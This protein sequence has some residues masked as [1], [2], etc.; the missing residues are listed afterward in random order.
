MGSGLAEHAA[1]AHARAPPRAGYGFT[2]GTEEAFTDRV[3]RG[4]AA[5]EWFVIAR[6]PWPVRTPCNWAT[7]PSRN[8][9]R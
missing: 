7:T 3:G 2:P 9:A 6:T 8:S 4:V 1:A 5:R